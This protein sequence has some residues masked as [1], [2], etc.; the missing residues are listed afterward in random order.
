MGD[1]T[2]DFIFRKLLQKISADKLDNVREICGEKVDIDD[3]GDAHYHCFFS[4]VS[5]NTACLGGTVYIKD[6]VDFEFQAEVG[7]QRVYRP[8][9]AQALG[10]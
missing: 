9:G 8:R 3:A 5:N 2:G 10:G 4:L 6:F 7:E 1:A